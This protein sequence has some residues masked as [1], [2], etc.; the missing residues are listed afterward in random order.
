MTKRW[1]RVRDGWR[2]TSLT[3]EESKMIST[4]NWFC[5]NIPRDGFTTGVP[6][7]Y[8]K[9]VRREKIL[10]WCHN[11]CNKHWVEDGILN[12]KFEDEEDLVMFALRWC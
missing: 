10:N 5:I 12:Y 9:T 1:T 3:L 8:I 6:M 11:H 7:E 4:E 2:T